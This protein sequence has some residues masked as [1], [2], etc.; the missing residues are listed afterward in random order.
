MN[1]VI[2]ELL[3]ALD[4]NCM[5]GIYANTKEDAIKIVKDMLFKG[6]KITNGG[7]VTLSECGIYDLLN[8]GDYNYLDRNR[9]GI[10]EEE[11]LSVYK[12]VLDSDFYFCSANAITQNGELINVDGRCNRISAIS[13]GP[14]KVILIVGTN[15][16]VK[17]IDEGF[18][19][20]KKIAAPKNCVR[21]NKNTPCAKLGYCIS[22]QKSDNPEITDGCDSPDRICATYNIIGKQMEK[23]RIVVIICDENLGY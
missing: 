2:E 14:K 22:L 13:F 20:I 15:K 9:K 16:I 10:T 17:D 21:L 6:A 8:N 18:L 7:S 5:K 12:N 1:K 11:R 23:D 3:K 19:R 4:K